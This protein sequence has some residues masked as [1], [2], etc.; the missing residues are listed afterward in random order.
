MHIKLLWAC[1]SNRSSVV[2]FRTT[3][4]LSQ[5]GVFPPPP[6][7]PPARSLIY[8]VSFVKFVRIIALTG[9]CLIHAG[10]LPS[11]GRGET[12]P[13]SRV[14]RS[15]S[16]TETTA[17]PRVKALAGRKNLWKNSETHSAQSVWVGSSDSDAL[18]FQHHLNSAMRHAAW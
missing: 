14:G 18:L 4:W 3:W 6:V 17:R 11:H 13:R 5:E 15:L 12:N 7:R 9:N 8:A 2:V 16:H 10:L 1:A